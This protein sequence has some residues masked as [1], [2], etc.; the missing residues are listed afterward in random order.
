MPSSA[1]L[2]TSVQPSLARGVPPTAATNA[3][4]AGNDSPGRAPPATSSSDTS[5]AENSDLTYASASAPL[6]SGANR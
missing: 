6:L 4:A 3:A 2:A 1:N 5:H